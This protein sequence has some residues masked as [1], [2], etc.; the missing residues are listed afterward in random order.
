MVARGTFCDVCRDAAPTHD[1]HRPISRVRY[2]WMSSLLIQ[3][4]SR[5][6]RISPNVTYS[7]T[8]WN[9]LFI[10]QTDSSLFSLLLSYQPLHS[11]EDWLVCHTREMEGTRVAEMRVVIFISSDESLTS[12]DSVTGRLFLSI[13][14]MSRTRVTLRPMTHCHDPYP[15]KTRH[16]NETWFPRLDLAGVS[17]ARMIFIRSQACFPEPYRDNLRFSKLAWGFPTGGSALRENLMSN[18]NSINPIAYFRSSSST[19]RP[20]YFSSYTFI[21]FSSLIMWKFTI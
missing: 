16:F 8:I 21:P 18:C 5:I 12:L 19:S 11:G 7:Q 20:K 6:V 1:G 14:T 17:R 3:F 10:T 13:W 15:Y 4:L 2:F 9:I